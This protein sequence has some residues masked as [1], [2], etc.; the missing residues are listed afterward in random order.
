MASIVSRECPWNRGKIGMMLAE[1]MG[2]A[3]SGGLLAPQ[4]VSR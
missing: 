4:D 3:Q 2:G 1:G